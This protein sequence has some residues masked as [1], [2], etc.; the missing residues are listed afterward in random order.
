MR[1]LYILE[2]NLL[3]INMLNYENHIKTK[4]IRTIIEE[5]NIVIS[6]IPTKLFTATPSSQ[7]WLFSGIQGLLFLCINFSKSTGKIYIYSFDDLSL[8]FEFEFYQKFN[9]NYKAFNP[10]FH[11]FEIGNGFVGFK[12]NNIQKANELLQSVTDLNP[13]KIIKIISCNPI[14][15][16]F[17]IQETYKQNIK[18]LKTKLSQEFLFKNSYL[19]DKQ[20][21]FNHSAIEKVINLLNFESNTLTVNSNRSEFGKLVDAN[22]E[23]EFKEK[24]N[25]KIN[26]SRAYAT[27]IYNNILSTINHI[28]NFTET[29]INPKSEVVKP[30]YN[31]NNNP[32]PAVTPKVPQVPQLQNTSKVPT[33]P[34]VP[35]VP[36]VPIISATK[37]VPSIPSIP[38]IP[39]VNSG[40]GGPPVPKINLPDF[41]KINEAK[42][43]AAQAAIS[44]PVVQAAPVQSQED[45]LQ[46]IQ[47]KMKNLQKAEEVS[48]E[49]AFVKP[50]KMSM[51]DELRM[52]MMNRTKPVDNPT[53]KVETPKIE[54]DS[55]TK[56]Q[57]KIAQ[58]EFKP[59]LSKPTPF[60]PQMKNEASNKQIPTLSKNISSK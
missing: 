38:N 7:S 55:E 12:F 29:P 32:Q 52:K 26:D 24:S 6:C 45:K 13:S 54:Q 19:T 21:T 28:P 60:I 35:T 53:P 11:Y 34:S 59:Q 41:N 1:H 23:L 15:K 40:K 25:L 2:N 57:E 50:V 22:I 47:S 3:I 8:Q 42:K 10:L 46:E 33:V 39:S 37:G 27:Q 30:Q 31:P 5:K 4:I 20:I 58:P 48:E 9:E 14:Q 18:A 17:E 56:P 36:Q 49:A 51:M 44:T 16:D 43:A